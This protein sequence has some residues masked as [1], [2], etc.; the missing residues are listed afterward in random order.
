MGETPGERVGTTERGRGRAR[1][2]HT[3]V[4]AWR[5][6]RGQTNRQ[7]LLRD[8]ELEGRQ[9]SGGARGGETGVAQREAGSKRRARGSSGERNH[10]DAT[11]K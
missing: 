5:R 10:G 6:Q 2:S 8:G 9:A 7:G 4:T 11:K 1:G 3:R